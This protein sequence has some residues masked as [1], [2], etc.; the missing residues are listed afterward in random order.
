MKEDGFEEITVLNVFAEVLEESLSVW[1][2]K[3]IQR[4][5]KPTGR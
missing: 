3:H 5:V 1:Y 4:Q 2:S